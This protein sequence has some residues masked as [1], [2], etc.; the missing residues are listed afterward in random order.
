MQTTKA[1]IKRKATKQHQR[2]LQANNKIVLASIA[3]MCQ[4]QM[5]QMVEVLTLNKKEQQQ[6]E[7]VINWSDRCL[8]GLELGKTSV[9]QAMQIATSMGELVDREINQGS[10]RIVLGHYAAIW[11][12]LGYLTDEA[13]FRIAPANQ[14]RNWNFLAS[15]TNTWAGMMLSHV[16]HAGIWE[17]MGGELS[18]KMWELVF[19]RPFGKL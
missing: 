10:S 8:Y 19:R 13:R 7:R 4:G 15:V 6:A 9:Q 16:R 1:K 11:I 5:K 17:S 14:T 12:G 18:E 2:R 3:A